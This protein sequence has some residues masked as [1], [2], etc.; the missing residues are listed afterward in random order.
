MGFLIGTAGTP[1]DDFGFSSSQRQGS[2]V[3]DRAA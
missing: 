1:N 3:P 2:E